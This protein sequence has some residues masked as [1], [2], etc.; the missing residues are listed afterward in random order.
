MADADRPNINKN[1]HHFSV[2]KIALIVGITLLVV[3]VAIIIYRLVAHKRKVDKALLK[4]PKLVKNV[5]NPIDAS[6]A[7]LSTVGTEY[8]YN[9]WVKISDPGHKV[10]TP[11]CILYRANHSPGDKTSEPANPSVWLY[12]SDNKL[13]VR[14][15]T[16]SGKSNPSSK[17]NPLQKDIYPDF[18][19]ARA[20]ANNPHTYT[21]VNPLNSQNKKF[22]TP[23]VACDVG[24]LPMQR[25]VQITV[26]QW[27]QTL[28]V[29]INGKLV[30]SCVLPGV[31]LH[32]PKALKNIYVGGGSNHPEL[33]FN[34]YVSRLRY[35]DHAITAKQVMDLYRKGPVAVSWWWHTLKNRV[36][37][38][39]NIGQDD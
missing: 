11:K 28:D 32:D 33:D 30:R 9:I 27:N 24:N 36:E 16:L 26:V 37:V 2:R 5:Q 31:P 39:L 12:P 4:L 1:E 17:A 21:V 10:N 15:S 34:G 29:Y 22:M 25:W 6:D 14:V 8:T 3:I 19:E 13:M 35:F 23:I 38:S 7:P 18:A 20:S